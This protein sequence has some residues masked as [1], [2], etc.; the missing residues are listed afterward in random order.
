MNEQIRPSGGHSTD[1]A[2]TLLAMPEMCCAAEFKAVDKE[3]R[4]V[5]GVRDVTADFIRRSVRVDHETVPDVDLLSAARRSGFVVR[6]AGGPSSASA[7]SLQARP[8]ATGTT[9]LA[10]PEMCCTAEFG[11]IDKELRRIA[12]VSDVT[13]DFIRRSVRIQHAAA[14]NSELLGAVART[15]FDVRLANTPPVPARGRSLGGIPIRVAAATADKPA[16][17]AS[18]SNPSAFVQE[19]QPSN[20]PIAVDDA[21]HEQDAEAGGLRSHWKL[22]G[23]AAL[24]IAAEG[25]ALA[26][27][28]H[29]PLTIIPA[30]AA[31]LLAGVP[32][33]RKGLLALRRFNLNITALMTVA[34]TGAAILGQWPEAAMV[35]VL[36]AI[37]E[38]IEDKSLDRARC[39]VEGLMSMAPETA[40]V[41]QSGSWQ[42]VAA[43]AVPVDAIVR[44]RPGE[45]IALDGKVTAG[46]SAVNQAA[47]TGE[48]VPVDKAAGDT[49]FAG[50]INQNGELQ[51]RVT[52]VSTN[53]TLARIIRSVQEAQGTRAPTQRFIDA[54][55]RVYTPA[56]FV[57]AIAVAALPPLLI[58][59]DWFTWI[60]RALVLL[61]IACPC[62]L[63]LS[64]PISVVSGLTAAARRGILIKGGLYLEQGHRLKVLALDKTGTLT[65]G[66]PVVTDVIAL[67]GTEAEV[68]SAASALSGRSD[69]PVSKAVT[70]HAGTSS[71]EIGN[72]AALQGRGVE[73]QIDGV[74]YRLGNHRLAEESGACS[75]ELER[76]LDAL[77][78]QGKTAIVLVREQVPVAIF[79]IADTVRPESTTAIAELKRL[80]IEPVMLTGDNRHTA[81]AIARQVGITNVRSELLP[82]EKSNIVAQLATGSKVVGMV[83]D[84]INDA[85]ALSRANIGFAMGAVGTDTAIETADV[86]LMDDDPR[87]LAEFVR[88]SHAT[89]VVLWQNISFALGIK[90]VFLT[91]AITGQ[92]T[93]WM[94]VFADMGGSLLVVANGL[95]LLRKAR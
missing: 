65:Q 59:A 55:A 92:A 74:R 4:R 50:T 71:I 86:A 13:A 84:G 32:T 53:S 25:I 56:V 90:A 73:G 49:L 3:L 1:M 91:L 94:A 23:G 33:Y 39:A 28:D 2:S 17:S 31:I 63:V 20:V 14:P 64:T 36:F 42:E 66:R 61:I 68:L 45:R 79:A 62:A 47:I 95:R 67:Q 21:D 35:T 69:H 34:V 6:L 89:K 72:F 38:M 41:R 77:E 93:L 12:G 80:G 27:G 40:T 11:A 46:A 30:V 8:A 26:V 22:I 78:L 37:A 24:A 19:S 29:S 58:G 70:Q 75:P 85:P 15:G 57:A 88:L 60:Y 16:E 51:Y 87:K 5:A 81:E 10:V 18:E 43:A 7:S 9:I 83:G 52:A 82:E 76:Q 44:V 54:F 48:S